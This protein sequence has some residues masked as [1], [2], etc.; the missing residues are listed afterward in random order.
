MS[1]KKEKKQGHELTKQQN[2]E[3]IIT[4]HYSVNIT[5]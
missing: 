4:I 2:I 5:R 1:K 3:N